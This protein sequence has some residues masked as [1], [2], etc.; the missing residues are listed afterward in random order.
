MPV[1]EGY[2]AGV[3]LLENGNPYDAFIEQGWT[4]DQMVEHE[5]IVVDQATAPVASTD[6]LT[7]QY[8]ALRDEKTAIEKK[9]KA[10]KKEKTDAMEEIEAQLIAFLDSNELES[11]STASGTIYKDKLTGVSNSDRN[12]FMQFISGTILKS[13]VEATVIDQGRYAG[14]EGAKV[15][16]ADIAILAADDAWA[17]FSQTVP[18]AAA[19]D[20]LEDTE[21]PVPGLKYDTTNT[22]KIRRK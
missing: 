1:P 2:K 15:W 19:M 3:K 6:D 22:I 5:W 4:L 18:K 20:Y 11:T 17:F 7:R 21:Q 16:A 9:A 8:V 12:L 14:D 10:D 13:L